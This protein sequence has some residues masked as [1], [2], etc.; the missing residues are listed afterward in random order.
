M[1]IKWLK[2]AL[3]D[4]QSEASYIADN[5]LAAAKK[6]VTDVFTVID[7]LK[8]NPSLGRPGRVVGTREL[9]VPNTP[10]IIPYRVNG[11]SQQVEILRVFHTS[12][13]VP[14]KW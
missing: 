6:I 3:N 7:H 10:Y 11:R 5:D 12:R 4:L 9:I 1:Q 8:D 2:R 13:K 14:S